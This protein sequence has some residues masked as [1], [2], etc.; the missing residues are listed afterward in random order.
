[1][2]NVKKNSESHELAKQILEAIRGFLLGT[3]K[4]EW[5]ITVANLE[6]NDVA[7]ELVEK[8]LEGQVYTRNAERLLVH[9]YFDDFYKFLDEQNLLTKYRDLLPL[10]TMKQIIAWELVS[11]WRMS[12]DQFDKE[13]KS[14]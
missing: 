7:I 5:L 9:E 8:R 2:P 11:V 6:V 1:V 13:E 3:D 10:D 12:R 14:E 4:E